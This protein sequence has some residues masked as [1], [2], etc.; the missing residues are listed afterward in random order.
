MSD[1]PIRPRLS[2]SAMIRRHIIDGEE[3]LILHD[4]AREEAIELDRDQVEQ[5]LACDGTRDLGG[6]MLE[7][8]RRHA[9]ARGSAIEALL[10]ESQRRGLLADGIAARAFEPLHADRPLE[11]LEGYRL[12]CDG[13]GSCC[14]TYA[15]VPFTR[16]ETQRA[17][18]ICPTEGE[19]VFLP[20]FGAGDDRLQAVTMIDGACAFLGG[21]HKCRIHVAAGSAQKPR[22]CRVFPATHVDD[23]E[24]VRVSVAV[25]CAC[26]LSSLGTGAGDGLVTDGATREAEL[27]E[28]TRVVRLPEQIRLDGETMAPRAELRRWSAAIASAVPP[29]IDGVAALWGLAEAVREEG[30]DVEATHVAVAAPPPSSAALGFHLMAL[31]GTTA[32][33]RATVD[34]WR[35]RTDRV[36]RLASW[37]DDAAQALLDRSVVEARLGEG[38]GPLAGHEAFHLRALIHGHL[39]AGELSLFQALRDRAVRQLLARQ[40]FLSPVDDPSA[41][42][43]LTAVEAMMRG[44]G[45]EAYARAAG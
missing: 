31:A 17:L 39:L 21:D 22:G 32:D 16:S 41:R 5:L 23:G 9:Y 24:A 34:G 14:T 2:D 36:R 12:H 11:V 29:Q 8:A 18:G 45:L 28:G 15:S 42:Y 7:A 13:N 20:L 10:V 35:G 43:P 3:K 44:Q 19:R 4:R 37:L 33:K 26:V 30:L 40:A 1:L 25:E 27:V 38:P 6:I